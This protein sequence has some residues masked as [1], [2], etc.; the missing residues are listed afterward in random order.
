M[1]TGYGSFLDR[2]LVVLSA[3]TVTLVSTQSFTNLTSNYT[4]IPI[5]LDYI[6]LTNSTLFIFSTTEATLQ[7]IAIS[8][9]ESW[10]LSSLRKRN[11]LVYEN[12]IQKRKSFTMSWSVH[13]LWVFMLLPFIAICGYAFFVIQ[14]R[15]M[16][17]S[18]QAAKQDP[19]CQ[20]S[21]LTKA[22]LIKMNWTHVKRPVPVQ[23]DELNVDEF[24]DRGPLVLTKELVGDVK[25][26]D[27]SSRSHIE[28]VVFDPNLN[29]IV[30]IGTHVEVV[31]KTVDLS[32][33]SYKI[34]ATQEEANS[35][36]L[37][38]IHKIANEKTRHNASVVSSTQPKQASSSLHVNATQE[39]HS[40]NRSEETQEDDE[41]SSQQMSPKNS[42]KKSKEVSSTSN[43]VGA[44]K[45]ALRPSEN[46]V[47]EVAPLGVT[48]RKDEKDG[49]TLKSVSIQKTSSNS[50]K[51]QIE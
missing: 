15:R 34:A 20:P 25:F 1:L 45:D 31:P 35:P 19:S 13:L 10:Q 8:L 14:R 28:K 2:C 48:K 36:P 3:T 21:A 30:D 33:K 44:K 18:E 23:N 46:H 32:G 4:D 42:V 26:A 38:S 41:K 11:K 9:D 49:S 24:K 12:S 22:E 47:E 43:I 39:N 17:L 29:E 7:D 51:P 40:R 50:S 27:Q 37:I 6:D 5:S 16:F